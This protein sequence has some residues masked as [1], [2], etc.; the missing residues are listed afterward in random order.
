MPSGSVS[1]G[2]TA[3]DCRV[4]SGSQTVWTRQQADRTTCAAQAEPLGPTRGPHPAGP[5]DRYAGAEGGRCWQRGRGGTGA[6]MRQR[7]ERKPKGSGWNVRVGLRPK[8]CATLSAGPST[9]MHTQ[10][11]AS[12]NAQV[13]AAKAYAA[14]PLVLAVGLGPRGSMNR[15]ERAAVPRVRVWDAVNKCRRLQRPG[16]GPSGVRTVSP[17]LLLH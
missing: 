8:Q 2:P 12:Y 15:P 16:W 11:D 14:L 10:W 3:G 7:G 13:R 17:I 6:R 9:S 1:F 5:R 4:L